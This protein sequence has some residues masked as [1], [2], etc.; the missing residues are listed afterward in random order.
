M[1][2]FQQN[3][4]PPGF[5]ESPFFSPFPPHQQRGFPQLFP[6]MMRQAPPI[7]S[8]PPATGGGIPGILSTLLNSGSGQSGGGINLVGMLMNAQ[9]AIQTA[10]TMIPM[11]QQFGPLI[12]NAPAILS[13]LRSMQTSE[14]SKETKEEETV[15]ETTDETVDSQKH[16]AD[17]V[18]IKEKSTKPVKA[19]SNTPVRQTRKKASN[20]W[21]TDDLETKPSRPR[22]YI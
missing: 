17:T 19:V 20:L 14:E 21:D 15:P 2:P 10:Q 13:V 9:K 22:M 6:S 4:M 18:D 11:V 3:S 7:P 8:P 12:K 1:P 16:N 5:R